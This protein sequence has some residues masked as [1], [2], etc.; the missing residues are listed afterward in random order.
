V[1]GVS[2]GSLKTNKESIPICHISNAIFHFLFAAIAISNFFFLL[3]PISTDVAQEMADV[4]C[5]I[6]NVKCKVFS[7]PRDNN[8]LP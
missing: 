3:T 4:K 1:A 8:L 2:Y 5:Q 6:P 7:I